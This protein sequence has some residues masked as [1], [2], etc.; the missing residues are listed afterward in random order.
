MCSVGSTGATWLLHEE[1][2]NEGWFMSYLG[3]LLECRFQDLHDDDTPGFLAKKV[4]NSESTVG[5]VEPLQSPTDG[6]RSAGPD[7]TGTA[8]R[9]R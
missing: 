9:T 3:R 5:D 7:R 2:A 1:R 6:E 4:D 8:H